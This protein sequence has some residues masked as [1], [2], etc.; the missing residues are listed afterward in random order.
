[1][2]RNGAVFPSGYV[3]TDDSF[4]NNARGQANKELFGWRSDFNSGTGAKEF[5]L[6]VANSRRFSQCMTQRVFKILCK[7]DIE[8]IEN[9]ES[10]NFWA[11]SFESSGYKMKKLFED[12]A[13]HPFC[14][15]DDV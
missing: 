15:G 2:N 6:L 9:K 8:K 5:G 10:L 4:I 11:D 14:L 1:M 13:I 7:K 3:T 12:I